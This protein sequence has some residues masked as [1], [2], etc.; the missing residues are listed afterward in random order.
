MAKMDALPSEVV[1]V[2]EAFKGAG[3]ATA[4]FVTNYNV[5]PYFNFHQGFDDYEYL[6][7]SFVL[8]ANDTAA[9]LLLIQFLRQ[10]IETWRAKRGDVEPGSAYQDAETVNKHVFG[11]LKKSP[12][13]KPWFLFVGYMDPHDPYFPHPYNGQGY[14]RAAHQSPGLSEASK[15]E[16]LYDGEINY[17]DAHFGKLVAKLKEMGVYDHMTIVVTADHGEEFGEHGGFFH[18]T[19]LYDEQVHVPLFIKLPGGSQAGTAAASW[20][21]LVDVAPTL[22]RLSN[23]NAPK[24]MQ[25]GDL[26]S[27]TEEVFAEENHEGNVLYSMRSQVG[28]DAVKLIRANPGNPRKLKPTELYKI[29]SDKKEERDVSELDITLRNTQGTR[30]AEYQDRARKGASVSKKVNIANDTTTVERLK[31]LGY[32]N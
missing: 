7:P 15:L 29:S 16:T 5:A 19:T 9:K 20:V 32:G 6:E 30:L 12:K 1:T 3:Y 21:Q 31:A 8:G 13:K 10:R 11:W 23:I 2:A 22:L 14:A 25:G 28:A 26:F 27:G 17:W 18:G 4:G 24:G